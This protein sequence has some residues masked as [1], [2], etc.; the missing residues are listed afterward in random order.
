M[1]ARKP[2]P[3]L[4][5]SDIR[6]LRIFQAVVRQQGFAAAQADLGLTPATISNH[7]AHLEARLGVRLCNRGRKGFSLTSEGARVH[8]AS[9][10]LLRS[11]ENFSSIIGSVRG[12][13]TGSVHFGTVDAMYT[14]PELNLHKA[15]AEFSR[16]APNVVVHI[17]I[18]SPHDLRQRLLDGRYQLILTPI[19]DTHPSIASDRLFDE[20]QSLYCG[21]GHP[22][23]H[24]PERR[25]GTAL[26]GGHRYAART[27]MKDWRGHKK[28]AFTV[29][30]MTSHMESLALL[31]LS[32][33]HLG[34]LPAHYARTWV[35]TGKMRCL[36]PRTLSYTDTF[37]LAI[38]SGEQNRAVALLR[39][40]I[41]ASYTSAHKA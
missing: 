28:L 31:I 5:G 18:S 22:L 24:V 36:L 32:G 39:D 27:Y 23:F 9:L 15:L 7:I 33:T 21:I 26:R 20:E 38:I 16:R 13:L 1:P 30:A 35:E 6:L 17:D 4:S 41:R 2:S 40:C 29:T 14:N 12:E 19:E 11:A 10:N 37:R 3:S 25:L 8:E 34:H